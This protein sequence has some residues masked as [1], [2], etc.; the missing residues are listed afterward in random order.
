MAHT[1]T[2]N[3]GWV[4][5]DVAG[6]TGAWGALLNT[7]FNAVDTAL[8]AVSDVANAA[9]ARA[10]GTMTGLLNVKT[11]SS[12]RVDKGSVSGTVV[13]DLTTAQY[14]ILTIGGAWTPDF[15]NTAGG[16]VVQGVTLRMTNGG[17]FVATW[18]ASFK[19]PSATPPTFTVSGV[20]IL[21][22]VTDDNSGT[23]RFAGI[24]KD[25]R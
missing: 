22:F 21:A 23:W 16:A 19:F 12:A 7:I 14:F 5:P 10:G 18:P 4:P 8:K 25:V 17:A 24:Q 9:L 3:Y 1:P 11:A 6:S 13:F 2:A 20:D 15:Q